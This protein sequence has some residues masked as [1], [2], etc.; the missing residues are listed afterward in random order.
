MLK[1]HPMEAQPADFTRPLIPFACAA[2]GGCG[3]GTK[4]VPSKS[5]AIDPSIPAKDIDWLWYEN[6]EES[7]RKK[8]KARDEQRRQESVDVRTGGPDT[9]KGQK[10]AQRRQ[11]AK[12][13]RDE[14]LKLGDVDAVETAVDTVVP[15]E[16][17]K[18]KRSKKLWRTGVE[19]ADPKD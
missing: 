6:W 12:Q 8:E 18:K 9:E 3:P 11:R 17:K 7:E 16:T 14:L 2:L 5:C 1:M 19:P 15:V 4:R 10:V 13:R